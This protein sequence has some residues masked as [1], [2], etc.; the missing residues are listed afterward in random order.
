M[1]KA[2]PGQPAGRTVDPDASRG[3]CRALLSA[4]RGTGPSCVTVSPV[5]DRPG[6]A[7]P[8]PNVLPNQRRDSRGIQAATVAAPTTTAS[9]PG[10]TGSRVAI[11]KAPKPITNSGTTHQG[12]RTAETSRDTMGVRRRASR[13]ATTPRSITAVASHRP[14]IE[15]SARRATRRRRTG[16]SRD[17]RRRRG[18]AQAAAARLSRIPTCDQ[19]AGSGNTASR[20]RCLKKSSSR[21]ASSDGARAIPRSNSA[22]RPSIAA[23]RA[24]VIAASSTATVGG[25]G[26][27]TIPSG[28]STIHAERRQESPTMLGSG[29]SRTP[30][31]GRLSLTSPA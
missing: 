29:I 21:R 6:V 4:D 27:A 3:V 19:A 24:A 5:T 17:W 7:R 8:R 28:S 20:R 12:P 2:S 30:S 9:Q 31:T 26:R 23:R 22:A 25:S 10:Q 14:G 18:G 11:H 13:S 1:E 15:A 16:M